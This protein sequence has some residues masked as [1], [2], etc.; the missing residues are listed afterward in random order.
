MSFDLHSRPPHDFWL[1]LDVGEFFEK[2]YDAVEIFEGGF[3]RPLRLSTRDVL[4]VIRWNENPEEPI[5]DVDVPDQDGLSSDEE[6]D[7]RKQLGRVLGTDLDVQAFAEHVEDDPE[8]APIVKKHLGFKRI[9]RADFYEDAIRYVIHTRISDLPTAKRM[10]QDVCKTWG[11]AFEWRGR[12]YY[13]YPRPEVLAAVEPDAFREYGVSRR[14]GSTSRA[15]RR[16]SSTESWTWIGSR[17]R[18]PQ[19]STSASR[20]S[21][22]SDRRPRRR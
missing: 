2:E 14:R 6:T 22:A 12:S 7:A 9:A 21:E 1:T 10:V 8:L 19:T 11:H 17:P 20:T 4:A 3:A 13:C 16:R 15:W 18:A 5:F